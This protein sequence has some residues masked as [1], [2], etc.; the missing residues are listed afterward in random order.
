MNVRAK[1]S[2]LFILARGVDPVG[3]QDNVAIFFQIPPD[4]SAGETEM[5]H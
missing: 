3:K 4:R 2:D 1:L 5:T